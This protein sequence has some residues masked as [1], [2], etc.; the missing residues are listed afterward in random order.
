[1]IS[2]ILEFFLRLITG[3]LFLGYYHFSVNSEILPF[4]KRKFEMT[5]GRFVSESKAA[6][7]R[8]I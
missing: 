5:S 7:S 8:R 4:R 2:E 6:Q 1:M 3:K